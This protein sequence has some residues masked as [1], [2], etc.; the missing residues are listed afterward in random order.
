M[1][2]GLGHEWEGAKGY[3][4]REGAMPAVTMGR[5]V[6]GLGSRGVLEGQDTSQGAGRLQGF[7][8]GGFPRTLPWSSVCSS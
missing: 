6:A 2:W 5:L 8:Q 4:G 3:A 7:E 1:I